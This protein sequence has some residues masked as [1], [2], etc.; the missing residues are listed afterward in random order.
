MAFASVHPHYIAKAEKKGRTKA[1]VRAIIHW[2]TG[3][4]EKALQ[5][6]IETKVDFQTFFAQAP[7]INPNVSKITGV[8]CGYRVQQMED[9]LM[10][11]IR[12]LDKLVDELAKG[13]AMDKILR[14]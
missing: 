13:K 10:Q 6:Q 8:I 7:R 3:Y 11:Q 1:E 5:K 9:K 14:K 2:L 4:D 12:Y